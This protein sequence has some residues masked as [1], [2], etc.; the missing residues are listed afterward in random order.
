MADPEPPTANDSAATTMDPTQTQVDGTAAKLNNLTFKFWPPTQRTRGAVLKRLLETLSSE[1]VLSKRYGMIPEEEASALA[2][3]IEEDAF[4]AA[5]A[6]FF[7]GDDGIEILQV[8]SREISKRMLDTAKAR[9]AAVS[10]SAPSGS[11]E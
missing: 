7:T 4:S 6:S 11:A 5:G 8:Y 3:L 9:A 1:S 2:K 10:D